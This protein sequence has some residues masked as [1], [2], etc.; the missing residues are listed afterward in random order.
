[1]KAALVTVALLVLALGWTSEAVQV[2][3]NGL[4]FSLEAVKRLQELTLSRA[5]AGPQNPRLRTSTVSLCADPMLPQEF[6][7]ICKQ[8]GASASLSRLAMVPLDVCEICAFAA[9]T[10]C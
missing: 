8:R 4:S 9:C 3:E 5:S 2:Q 10:G 6:L 1:M 7:P